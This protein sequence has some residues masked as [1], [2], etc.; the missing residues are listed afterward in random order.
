MMKRTPLTSTVATAALLSIC[1]LMTACAGTPPTTYGVRVRGTLHTMMQQ[2]QTRATSTLGELLPD[3]QVY[4]VGALADLSG[5]V[6][7]VG[8]Q[9]YL[10]YSGGVGGTRTEKPII[11]NAGA[12]LLVSAAVSNWQSV[13]TTA[14]IRYRDLDRAIERLARDAGID[15]RERFPF[16]IEGELEQL[17]WHVID[18]R[19]LK[20]GPA[21]HQDHLA[22][23]TQTTLERASA[24]LVGFYSDK[25]QGVFTHM[26]SRTHI[27]CVVEDPVATGHVDHVIIPTGTTIKFASPGT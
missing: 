25:D 10:S 16:L 1:W 23:S 26:G 9:A 20:S 13:V 15:V 11:T 4:A 18:G 3:P 12:T 6:T 27:H 5:E 22:A 19:R 21:S 7:V 14:P 24:T 8:G 17:Q 2:G